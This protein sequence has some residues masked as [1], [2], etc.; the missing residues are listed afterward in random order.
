MPAATVP[1]QGWLRAERWLGE[2]RRQGAWLWDLACE[3][4]TVR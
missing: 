2:E 3:E 1:G 4:G